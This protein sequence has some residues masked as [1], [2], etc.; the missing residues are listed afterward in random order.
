MIRHGHGAGSAPA[1]VEE[2]NGRCSI[3]GSDVPACRFPRLATAGHRP[4]CGITSALGEP[5]S[6]AAAE[7]IE[8]TIHRAIDLGINYFDTAPSYGQGRSEELLGRGLRGQRERVIVATKLQGNDAD[9]ARRSVEQSLTRLGIDQIDVLQIHGGWYSL[10]QVH[11]ILKPG[12]VLA[13]MRAARDEG[14]VRYLGFTSEGVNGAV[15]ELIA[16]SEFDVLQICYNVIFQHPYE[17][18][19][20][21][22]VMYEATARDMGLVAM[23]PLT[24]GIFPRWLGMVA[25]EAMAQ[26]DWH[27]ALLAFVLSNPLLSSA[28]VGMRS[29]EEVA[30]NVAASEDHSLRIDLD[31]L[32]ERYV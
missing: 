26:V 24:S 8:R 32:H 23:R 29:P 31:A 13:G 19:R 14:L 1:L 2:G 10:E 27:R 7:A 5:E 30:S 17:P 20:H 12:G 25:G 9:A 11:D 16:T 28:I 15:S 18:S 21:A 3:V 22:G 6:E 4:G